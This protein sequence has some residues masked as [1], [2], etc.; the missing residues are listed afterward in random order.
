MSD[1]DSN[2]K[3]RQ[4]IPLV[5]NTQFVNDKFNILIVNKNTNKTSEVDILLQLYNIRDE[6][7]STIN[8]DTTNIKYNEQ[9][10]FS[11]DF[12]N[13]FIPMTTCKNEDLS[14]AYLNLTFYVFAEFRSLGIYH[15]KIGDYDSDIDEYDVIDY[16]IQYDH[17]YK[18]ISDVNDPTNYGIMIPNLKIILRDDD[19]KVFSYEISK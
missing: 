3:Y 2:E 16:N 15:Y 8:I 18:I 9:K 19:I 11:Y 1:C 6:M 17:T 7:H 10:L 12:T 5:N 14:K 13:K 4:T